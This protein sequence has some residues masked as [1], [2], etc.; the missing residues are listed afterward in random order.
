MSTICS[1][2]IFAPCDSRVREEKRRTQ[3]KKTRQ[4]NRAEGLMSKFFSLWTSV[5]LLFPMEKEK[6]MN[7]NNDK[8]DR[9]S[10]F[11][12][13]LFCFGE[14]QMNMYTYILC[15]YTE[16]KKKDTLLIDLLFLFIVQSYLLSM[17]MAMVSSYYYSNYY[18]HPSDWC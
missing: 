4:R 2:S 1:F 18:F 3:K 6:E 5:L 15:L 14:T 13:F 7:N 8:C 9:H 16:I 11:L 17:R 10:A 12:R